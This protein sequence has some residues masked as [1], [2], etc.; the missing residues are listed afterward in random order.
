MLVGKWKNTSQLVDLLDLLHRL[1]LPEPIVEI[2][3]IFDPH[4]FVN[5]SAENKNNQIIIMRKL[6]T[7]SIRLHIIGGMRRLANGQRICFPL[8]QNRYHGSL[9][10]LRHTSARRGQPRA[11]N[12]RTAQH[13]P[14]GTL[15]DLLHRQEEGKLVEQPQRWHPR[16]VPM[17]EEQLIAGAVHQDFYVVMA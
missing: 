5:L 4:A 9:V 12:V 15:V 11:H 16:S 13:K 2:V 6:N 3:T 7:L 17:P 14:D 1:H 10:H 8:G